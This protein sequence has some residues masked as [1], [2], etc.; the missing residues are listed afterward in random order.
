[1]KIMFNSIAETQ[2][3]FKVERIK[4]DGQVDVKT[5]EYLLSL[6]GDEQRKVLTTQLADL[7]KDLAKLK[8]PFLNRRNG[9]ERRSTKGSEGNRRKY[10][11]ESAMG[12]RKRLSVIRNALQNRASVFDAWL[13][14]L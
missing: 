2:K 10:F 7:R 11:A 12:C 9:V 14:R 1:M 8:N 5:T 6:S 13:P 4:K 3:L